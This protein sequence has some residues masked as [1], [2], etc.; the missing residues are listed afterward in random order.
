M[1][2]VDSEQIADTPESE[3]NDTSEQGVDAPSEEKDEESDDNEENPTSAVSN[4][5]PACGFDVGIGSSI[6]VVCGNTLS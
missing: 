4:Q 3:E 1:D 5:C 6:C 2:K